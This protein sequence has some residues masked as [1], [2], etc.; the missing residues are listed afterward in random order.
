MPGRASNL[1]C[2][3]P[4][5]KYQ[6]SVEP[7]LSGHPRGF[8]RSCKKSPHGLNITFIIPKFELNSNYGSQVMRKTRCN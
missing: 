1:L 5:Q 7:A 3:K 8:Y 4:V 6:C 2:C